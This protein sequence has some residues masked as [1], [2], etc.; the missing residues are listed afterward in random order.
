M[1]GTCHGLRFY[2]G[3]RYE[4]LNKTSRFENLDVQNKRQA[5]FSGA[6]QRRLVF[7]PEKQVGLLILVLVLHEANPR[8]VTCRHD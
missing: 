8:A 3:I 5:Y 2:S 1:K 6:R 7:Y 4:I